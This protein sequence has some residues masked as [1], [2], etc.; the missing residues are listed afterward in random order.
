MIESQWTVHNL[1]AYLKDQ[2]ENAPYRKGEQ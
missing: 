1:L 2:P